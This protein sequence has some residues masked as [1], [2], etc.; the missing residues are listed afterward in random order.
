MSIAVITGGNSGIGRAAAVALA[1]R[2]FDVG[3]VWFSEEERAREAVAECEAHGV[4]ARGRDT[5][6]GTSS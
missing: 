3:I 2:G 6:R 5:T 1:E 4:R